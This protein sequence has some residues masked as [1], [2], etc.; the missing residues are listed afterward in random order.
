M[1]DVVK[2]GMASLMVS[3]LTCVVALGTILWTW[4]QIGKVDDA[5]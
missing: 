1:D 2:V 4:Y 3:G 5:E